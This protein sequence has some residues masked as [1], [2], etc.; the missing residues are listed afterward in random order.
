MVLAGVP[1]ASLLHSLFPPTLVYRAL[2]SGLQIHASAVSRL[3]NLLRAGSL[4]GFLSASLQHAH[5][6]MNLD[7]FAACRP[8]TCSRSR[9]ILE[10]VGP[11][12]VCGRAM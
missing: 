12:R 11:A 5:R 9:Y 10:P 4:S 6:P 7:L 1:A 3:Y 2:E 8:A